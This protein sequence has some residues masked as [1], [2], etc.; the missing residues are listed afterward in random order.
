MG[1]QVKP[2]TAL[3][4]LP[5]NLPNIAHAKL[6][7]AYLA[8]KKAIASA[9]KVDEC[10][11]WADKA[12]ALASYAKQADDETLYRHAIHIRARA[13][14]RCGALLAEIK[15]GKPG[16]QPE[17]GDG[18]VPQLPTRKAAADDAGLSERKRK[19][20]LRVHNYATAEPEAFEAAVEEEHA[21]VTELANRGVK[22]KPKPL[23]DLEGIDPEDYKQA[24]KASGELKRM[25]ELA[26][27]VEPD[28]VVRGCKKHE[29]TAVIE[30]AEV[31]LSWIKKLLIG[32]ERQT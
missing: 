24:T 16:P 6:P 10:K 17:L 3:Q 13:I 31:S 8:A 26:K 18:T 30:H 25:A 4:P 15:R 7:E 12:A 14:E 22:A 9:A 28:V 20:A 2:N 27:S 1:D 29:R 5:A 11:T 32:L 23:V 19:E 21:T